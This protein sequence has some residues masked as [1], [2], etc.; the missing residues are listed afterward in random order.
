MPNHSSSPEKLPATSDETAR[1]QLLR[2]LRLIAKD[3]VRR[4]VIAKSDVQNPS[5][6]AELRRQK[7]SAR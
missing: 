7:P 5:G 1:N 3:V 6:D 2:F 4:I